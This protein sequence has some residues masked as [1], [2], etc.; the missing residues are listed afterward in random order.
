MWVI[1]I[2]ESY[3]A[4]LIYLDICL[5]SWYIYH[6]VE[7]SAQDR[8]NAANCAHILTSEY[9]LRFSSNEQKRVNRRRDRRDGKMTNIK[10]RQ[11]R[12]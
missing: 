4:E 8:V 10:R 12:R 9:C 7:W 3:G 2:I 6:S 5:E 1:S 11:A